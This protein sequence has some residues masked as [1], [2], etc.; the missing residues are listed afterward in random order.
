MKGVQ[1]ALFIMMILVS[2]PSF[3]YLDLSCNPENEPNYEGVDCALCHGPGSNWDTL[4]GSQGMPHRALL[5][6]GHLQPLMVKR[7]P[8]R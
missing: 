6:R 1:T 4:C 2:A 5:P 8:S 3:A 7:C